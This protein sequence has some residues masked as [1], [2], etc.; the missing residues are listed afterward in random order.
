MPAV[1]PVSTEQE[2]RLIREPIES[3]SFESLLAEARIEMLDMN[4]TTEHDANA[5]GSASPDTDIRRSEKA[6]PGLKGLQA[7]E[8]ASIRKLIEQR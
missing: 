8:N 6:Y 4:E 5:D 3:R 2:T 7:I 1:K